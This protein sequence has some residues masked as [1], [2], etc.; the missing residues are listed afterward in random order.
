MPVPSAEPVGFRGPSDSH[1]C[2]YSDGTNWVTQA[3]GIEPSVPSDSAFNYAFLIT[4]NAGSAGTDDYY[5]FQKFWQKAAAKWTV[6]AGDET[7]DVFAMY[8]YGETN[9]DEDCNLTDI[10]GNA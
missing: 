2:F 8:Q 6:P 9:S 5:C 7:T 10:S 1:T 4:L 3:A